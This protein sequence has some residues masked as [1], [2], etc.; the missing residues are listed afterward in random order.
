[1]L[2]RVKTDAEIK[3]M[4]ESGRMLGEVLNILV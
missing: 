2:T 4:R 1:M 3:A